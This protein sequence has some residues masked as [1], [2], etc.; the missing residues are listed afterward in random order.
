[1]D[2][3]INREK[4][5]D[6]LT[7]KR[8]SMEP[9]LRER[10]ADLRERFEKEQ[11]T[12]I[13]LADWHRK[14]ADLL[15]ANEITVVGGI[16]AKPNGARH[17]DLPRRPQEGPSEV[18]RELKMLEQRL[19][20]VCRHHDAAIALIEMSEN[21]VVSISES[22]YQAL[23]AGDEPRPRNESP[24]RRTYKMD[25]DYSMYPRG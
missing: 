18:E 10:I 15:D 16:A 2:L 14:V 7:K 11:E 17:P 22:D 13:T 4:L 21:K 24:R 25:L 5:I 19:A 1:M 23:L 8:D 12:S 6:A 3:Q 9:E 20:H